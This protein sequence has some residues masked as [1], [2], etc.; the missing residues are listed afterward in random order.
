MYVW[1]FDA[2]SDATLAAGFK[3]LSKAAGI[4]ESVNDVQDFL[5]KM[6]E[7]WLLIFDNADDPNV[8]LSKYIPQ[9]NHGNIIITSRLTDQMA[10]PG[11]CL[12]FLIL[13]KVML[14]IF[15]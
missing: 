13:N 14:S 2:T 1:F 7:D 9:C 12:N 11:A 5:G 6:Q 4:N 3:K 15:F 10:S 8:E